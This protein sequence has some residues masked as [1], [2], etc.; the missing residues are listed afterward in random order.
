ML[1]NIN[2]PTKNVLTYLGKPSYTPSHPTYP[3]T[4]SRVK[5]APSAPRTMAS[6]AYK[7]YQM[8][9]VQ[10]SYTKAME[11]SDMIQPHFNG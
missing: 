7:L 5:V 11:N 8:P 1:G 9:M 4:V 6:S 2:P 3:C 10:N